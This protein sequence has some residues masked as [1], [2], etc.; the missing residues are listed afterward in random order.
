MTIKENTLMDTSVKRS[1]IK[2][3]MNK[4]KIHFI[5]CLIDIASFRLVQ[6]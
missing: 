2:Y 5:I 1:E 4:L 6:Q 3:S